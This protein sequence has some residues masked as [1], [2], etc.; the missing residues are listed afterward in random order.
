MRHRPGRTR[1]RVT[2]I[3]L[4]VLAILHAP[5]PQPDFHNIRHH[6]GEGQ[7]C[8]YHDHLLRW[9]PDARLAE[10]VPVLH[11][12]WVHPYSVPNE[13][14]SDGLGM[15]GHGDDWVATCDDGPS[16]APDTSTSRLSARGLCASAS[17]SGLTTILPPPALLCD[18]GGRPRAGESASGAPLAPR[19]SRLSVLQRWTC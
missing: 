4:L 10:D 7:V 15:H 14:Q 1:A 8:D 19:A 17:W 6:D 9:H 3:A 12:H 11:W 2:G 18:P 5:M 13:P 16:L